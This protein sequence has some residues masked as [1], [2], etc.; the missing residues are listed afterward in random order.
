M[1]VLIGVIVVDLPVALAAQ[2]EGGELHQGAHADSN[3]VLPGG[4]PDALGLGGGSKEG[5]DL[6]IVIGIHGGGQSAEGTGVLNNHLR[7]TEGLSGAVGHEGLDLGQVLAGA[8]ALGIH[9]GDDAHAGVGGDHLLQAHNMAILIQHQIEG[10]ANHVVGEA[11]VAVGA[12]LHVGVLIP[13]VQHGHVAGAGQTARQEGVAGH[14]LGAVGGD[15]AHLGILIACGGLHGHPHGGGGA[16][17]LAQLG[18][19]SCQELK[20]LIGHIIGLQGGLLG[21]VHGVDR[22]AGGALAAAPTLHQGQLALL[23][24]VVGVHGQDQLH[25]LVTGGNRVAQVHSGGGVLNDVAGGVLDGGGGVND[26]SQ[27]GVDVHEHPQVGVGMV[28]RIGFAIGRLDDRAVGILSPHLLIQLVDLGG[29]AGGADVLGGGVQGV[30]R[31]IGALVK[32]SLV[33]AG[34]GVPR[35]SGRRGLVAVEHLNDGAPGDGLIAVDVLGQL[36]LGHRVGVGLDGGHGQR[37][38]GLILALGV[39]PVGSDGRVGVN[40]VL[41]AVLHR[42]GGLVLH[43]HDGGTTELIEG[44][45]A[46]LAHDAEGLVHQGVGHIGCID[47]LTIIS[48]FRGVAVLGI[49]LA[50]VHQQVGGVVGQDAVVLHG[51]LDALEHD[52]GHHLTGGGAAQRA[53]GDLGG[54]AVLGA[55]AGGLE[56]PVVVAKLVGVVVAHGA[57]NHHQSLIAGDVAPGVEPVAAHAL[58]QAVVGA[59]VH[60][61]GEPVVSG[62]VGELAVVLVQVEVVPVH[63]AGDDAVQDGGHLTAG[64]G[65]LGHELAL[66]GVALA[67]AIDDAQGRQDVDG[68]GVGVGDVVGILVAAGVDGDHQAEGHQHRQNQREE[69]FQVSHWICFLLVCFLRE[70]RRFHRRFVPDRMGHPLHAPRVAG[71]G[72]SHGQQSTL[73]AQMIGSRPLS[74]GKKRRF[75]PLAAIFHFD[76]MAALPYNI[77]IHRAAGR[78]GRENAFRVEKFK[79]WTFWLVL[80]CF[81]QLRALLQLCYT[82]A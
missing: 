78:G 21:A 26:L 68:F 37:N 20:G 35:V 60:I 28:I 63:I 80:H 30:Q 18:L 31:H 59:E 40:N 55:V 42:V 25:Q 14:V 32:G 49:D 10:L 27:E 61:G 50:G 69:L 36:A 82:W 22:V 77:T 75:C 4:G 34:E 16:G 6:G 58:H 54:Q 33:H 56:L 71:E 43:P 2:A 74:R 39:S 81:V 38:L 45:G 73:T 62:H 13:L 5:V 3:T 70:F 7:H 15:D 53:G 8:N 79:I 11:L 48:V 17:Q 76:F 1:I 19:G 64:D 46:A 72:V 12:A 66:V 9:A 29:A 57:Q 52:L 24:L 41:R 65:V 47:E 51:G 44:Q 67:L 23:V